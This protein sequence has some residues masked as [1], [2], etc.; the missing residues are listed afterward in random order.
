MKPTKSVSWRTSAIAICAC[1]L[2]SSLI[3]LFTRQNTIKPNQ[4]ASSTAA[5]WLVHRASQ[6]VVLVDGFS[7]SVLARVD[8]GKDA[9]DA[10]TAQG[11]G[12]AFLVSNSTGTARSI[13][14][15]K[16]RLGTSRKLE[17]LTD[18]KSVV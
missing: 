12:G 7:G 18:R 15:A 10:V 14:T 1:L 2:A 6:Q 4:L 16:L 5:H 13:S 17:A 9:D 8:A 3:V 11:E